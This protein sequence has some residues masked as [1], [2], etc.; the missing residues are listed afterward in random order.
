M[1]SVS[2]ALAIISPE[3]APAAPD[4]PPLA[5]A[6]V[7]AVDVPT[8]QA[9]FAPASTPKAIVD[10]LNAEILAALKTDELRQ[11]L[12]GIMLQVEPS[13]P[14]ELRARIKRESGVWEQF[15]REDS[16]AGH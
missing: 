14:E 4:V 11:K 16:L 6:G 2:A 1:P 13:T 3:R 15:V 8:W 12:A 10:R 9:V 7:S 5:E